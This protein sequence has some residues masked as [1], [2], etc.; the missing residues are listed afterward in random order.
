MEQREIILR[1]VALKCRD[2]SRQLSYHR[3]L[4]KYK[5]SF[6]LNFWKTVSNNAIDLAVLDWLHL[7]G[8][9]S[10]DLHWKRVIDD[11]QGF[12]DGLLNHLGF[13]DQEWKTY[14]QTVKDYRNKDVAHI[15]VRPVSEVP[16]M[17]MALKAAEYY[18]KHVHCELE[19]LRDYSGWSDDLFDYYSRSL[20]EAKKIVALAYEPTSG[21]EERVN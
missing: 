17:T 15:E 12:K 18:Y 11:P 4:W 9:D 14:W 3:S 1:R 20:D 21:M 13:N 19:T 16:D 7:F 2:F 6:R 8:S 10:D 5:D